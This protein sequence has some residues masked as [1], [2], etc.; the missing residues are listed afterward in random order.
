MRKAFKVLY[1]II[2]VI[3]AFLGCTTDI[4][5]DLHQMMGDALPESVTSVIVFMIWV[6]L[7]PITILVALIISIYQYIK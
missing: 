4:M 6:L 3:I 1:F 7:W 2:G 5:D